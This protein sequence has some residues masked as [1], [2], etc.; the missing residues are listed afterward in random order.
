MC[1]KFLHRI[2]TLTSKFREDA[3]MEYLRVAQD[4]EMYGILY[5]PI[6]NKKD[7]DLHLGIS[8]Q[9][10]GIYKGSNRIT[11]RPFFSWS[12]I[13]NITFK[14]KKFH[15]KTVDKSGVSFRAKE[16]TMNPSILDLC[17][18]THNLYLRRRQPD[19]LEVFCF[20]A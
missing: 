12:E 10:L 15:M 8:A 20:I 18:G 11:P 17:I 2:F 3:E 5:Y 16:R 14:N 1:D 4:L 13:K 6:C 19:T 9:G 7:T